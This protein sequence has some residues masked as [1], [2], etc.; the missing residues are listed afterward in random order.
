M[1]FGSFRMPSVHLECAAASPSR[2]P[3]RLRPKRRR[4]DDFSSVEPPGEA[5]TRQAV[6]TRLPRDLCSGLEEGLR[7]VNKA[8]SQDKSRSQNLAE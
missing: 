1:V 5:I 6:Q 3:F 2:G 4:K 8:E 7:M